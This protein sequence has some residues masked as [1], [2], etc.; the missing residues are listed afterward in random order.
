MS[1][2]IIAAKPFD[3]KDDGSW[4]C[5]GIKLASL[6]RSEIVTTPVPTKIFTGGYLEPGVSFFVLLLEMNSKFWPALC[7]HSGVPLYWV[8]STVVHQSI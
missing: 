7:H 6:A 1:G 3:Q 4:S 2:R 8:S 5:L